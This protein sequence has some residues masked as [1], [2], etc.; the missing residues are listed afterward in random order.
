MGYSDISTLCEICIN[1]CPENLISIN[2]NQINVNDEMCLGCSNCCYVCP[3]DNIKPK[4]EYFSNGIINSARSVVE[5]LS[6]Y[7]CI[8][9][10]TNITGFCDCDE[11]P[12]PIIVDDIGI[13]L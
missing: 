5:N 9:Y 7:F 6:N 13:L 8:N 2:N 12:G 10:L 11:N 4:K 3:N 1:S